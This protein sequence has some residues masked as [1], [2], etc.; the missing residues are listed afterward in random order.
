MGL[1]RQQRSPYWWMWLEPPPAGKGKGESTKVRIDAPTP[2]LRRENKR[3][4]EQVYHLRQA[5]YARDARGLTP[6]ATITFSAYALWYEQ[7]AIVG[8]GSRSREASTLA[9][10]RAWFSQ[11]PL[12]LVDKDA[13]LEWRTHRLTEVA[14]STVDRELDVLKS[15]LASAA[16]KY[17]AAS[18][19]AGMKRHR[20]T[21]QSKKRRPRILTEDE[22]RRL[23][24]SA[25]DPTEHALM[26]VALDTLMRLSD[27]KELRRDRDYGSYLHVEAPKIDPYDVPVST[28]LRRALNRVPHTGP[29]YF[30]KRW[31]GRDGGMSVNTVWR[32]FRRLCAAAEIPVGRKH[33]GVT[34]HSLRHT[35][36]TR[37][38]EGGVNPIAVME[39]GGW[40]ELRQL[41][42]YGRATDETKRAAVNTRWRPRRHRD[43][44]GKVPKR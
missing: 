2:A 19:I 26:L 14:P 8:H 27:V 41:T 5:E 39:I 38:L 33:R 40:R 25:K 43:G 9:R 28:R 24:A 22:E 7:H 4:A 31:A 32:I 16:P 36:T 29:Y 15:V 35:G 23:L 17:L 20:E 13:V 6:K 42:R 18:P 3:L 21:V 34:F 44:A 30:P 37:M 11:T 10:L 1:Y 12:H